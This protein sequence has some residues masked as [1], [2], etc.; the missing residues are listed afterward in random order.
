[1]VAARIWPPPLA[2]VVRRSCQAPEEDFRESPSFARFFFSTHL[3]EALREGASAA[4][5]T[6]KQVYLTDLGKQTIHRRNS[7]GVIRVEN[8]G[9]IGLKNRQGVNS[10]QPRVALVAGNGNPAKFGV[11]VICG[12][13]C[14]G[15]V[16]NF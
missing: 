8:S 6:Q 13:D 3:G 9:S 14:D 2:K 12:Q 15:D 10:C 7:E 5:M 11:A 4:I 16:V 1:M